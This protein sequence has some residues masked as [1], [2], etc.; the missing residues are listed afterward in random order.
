MD[1][2]AGITLLELLTVIAL[3]AVMT[4]LAIP[5]LDSVMLNARRAAAIE[6]LVRAAWFARTEALRRG[7]PVVLCGSAGDAHCA[8]DPDAWSGGWLVAAADAPSV[9]LRRG[10]GVR[11]P[12]A[13]I[14]ANRRT[15]RFE[16]HDHRGTNGTL[17]WCDGRGETAARAVI[18]AP[19]GRPR[20]EHGPGSLACPRE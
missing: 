3:A 10:P 16:P 6:S 18:I 15:F 2:H 7:R 20:V 9:A 5:A 4:G 14:V 1:R 13:R 8:A 11:D 17:A 12:R 19:T